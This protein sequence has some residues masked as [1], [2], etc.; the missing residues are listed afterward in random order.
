MSWQEQ[1]TY[2]PSGFEKSVE[3]TSAKRWPLEWQLLRTLHDPDSIPDDKLP[4]LAWALSVD[5]WN[6]NWPVEKKRSVVRSAIRDH[7]IK[8]TIAGVRRYLEIEGADLVTYM[9]PP[10][11]IFASGALTKEE[12]D[13]WL[14]SMPQLRIYR[15]SRFGNAG[16]FGFAGVFFS[17][18][19]FA[20]LDEAPQNYGRF[21]VYY[22]KGVSTPLRTSEII[23]ETTT[24][25]VEIVEQVATRGIGGFSFEGDFE[26]SMFVD[27]IVVAAQLYTI[28]TD[29][30]YS[31]SES[32]LALN[33]A[34]PGLNPLNVRYKRVAEKGLAGAAFF[35][36]DFT[37]ADYFV[38]P[39]DAEWKM[40]D[41]IYLHDTSRAIP[42]V[43][44]LSFVDDARVSMDPFTSEYMID[45]NGFT[46]SIEKFEGDFA[47]LM[48]AMPEDLSRIEKQLDAVAIA[49]G[50]RDK[51]LVT[52]ETTRSRVWGDGYPLDGSVPL[53][54]RVDAA[55]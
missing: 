33:T 14:E 7:S 40:Y 34:T 44:S 42:L 41:V 16:S 5:L 45:S 48:F 18:Y 26:G 25:T 15:R 20:M 51:A 38:M 9:A 53:W 24:G 27:D 12:T 43:D 36:G 1:L 4:I 35:V 11:R 32:I 23:T 47:D 10:Q 55:L 31:H 28:R 13:A 52:F 54:S 29:R 37:D 6:N 21:P 46:D 19:D 2:D 50:Y 3:E 30:H 22:D 49:K 17:D 8:G 39:D